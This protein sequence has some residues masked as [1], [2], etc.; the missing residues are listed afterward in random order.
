MKRLTTI[1]FAIILMASIPI[2]SLKAATDR[3]NVLKI[4][5]WADYI[6]EDLLDEF[7]EWYKEQTGEDIEIIY[8][9]FDINEVML[10]KIETG[11]EDYDVVCPSE[12]IIERMLRND[13][14]QP[15]SHDFGTTP[16]YTE[17]VSPYFKELVNE[18]SAGGRKGADYAVGYMWG[19]TGL[20]YNTEQVTEQEA[21]TWGSVWNPKFQGR[22]LMKDAF[23]DVY[24]SLMMYIR[25]NE[26]SNGTVTRSQVMNDMSDKYLA[27]FT[28]TMAAAKS[29]ITGWEVDLGKERMAQGKDWINVTWSGDAMWAIDEV[30]DDVSLDYRVPDEGS[31]IWFDGWVIPKYA[32]NPKAASY[33]I[34]FMC[35]P[36][37]ALRN[38]DEI[39]YVSVIG[40]P[41]VLEAKID[42]S[43]PAIDLSYFFGPEADSV[44]V[45]S[46]QYPDAGTI[47]RCA[48]M[49]DSGDRAEAMIDMWSKVK[50]DSLNVTTI[51]IICAVLAAIFIAVL[52]SRKKKKSHRRS[53]VRR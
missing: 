25:Q 31:N 1:L 51:I 18:F 46:I 19:T 27:V 34:N 8:Q 10:T 49:H 5:N 20:L 33:F 45:N 35:M 9:L 40:S 3:E 30:G 6:D 29:N 23:R 50:G 37:N 42:D 12:Y 36:E 52:A 15:I 13:L 53:K 47:S 7:E 32:K 44:C 4:Y 11:H 39:G 28:D 16:D 43:C 38:M 48:L 17:N 24:G 2:L 21:S 41:E 26:I 14:L 22:I